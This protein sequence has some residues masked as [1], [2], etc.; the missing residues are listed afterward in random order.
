MNTVEEINQ[1]LQGITKNLI[2]FLLESVVDCI[3]LNAYPKYLLK[4]A[5]PEHNELIIIEAYLSEALCNLYNMVIYCYTHELSLEYFTIFFDLMKCVDLCNYTEMYLVH[6][7]AMEGVHNLFI[8][9]HKKGVYNKFHKKK[10]RNV[11]QYYNLLNVTMNRVEKRFSKLT[12]TVACE[13]VDP[14]NSCTVNMNNCYEEISKL[15]GVTSSGNVTPE[16]VTVVND[17]KGN[18]V[19]SCVIL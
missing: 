14:K 8:I 4:K 16:G 5:P 15:R 12:G 9:Q 3:N 6:C 7:L 17:P 11:K 10:F 2:R 1:E 18:P 13:V 19:Q